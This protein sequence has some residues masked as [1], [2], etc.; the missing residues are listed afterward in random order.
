VEILVGIH[1]ADDATLSSFDDRHS[2]P[3]ALT[4]H[5][6]LHP[7]ECMDRTVTRP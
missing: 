1:A 6:W 7:T 5:E 4:M 3:P 2:E